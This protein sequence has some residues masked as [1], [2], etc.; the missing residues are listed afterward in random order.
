[1]LT[2]NTA[3]IYISRRGIVNYQKWCFGVILK[4]FNSKY[5]EIDIIF[6]VKDT[7]SLVSTIQLL[8]RPKVKYEM[9]LNHWKIFVK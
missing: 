6:K 3:E 9:S 5:R 4:Q 1:M 8:L 2:L 7:Y